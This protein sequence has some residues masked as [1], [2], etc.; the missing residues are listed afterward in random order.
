MAGS[1]T[2][3]RR[4]GRSSYSGSRTRSYRYGY[5]YGSEAPVLYPEEERGYGRRS[6]QEQERVA[7]TSRK[8]A[9]RHAAVVNAVRNAVYV[10]VVGM[11]CL[12]LFNYISLQSAVTQSVKQIASYES[13]LTSLKEAN[14][15]MY[16][17]IVSSVDLDQIKDRAMNELG[18]TYA[19]E[20]QILS[21]QGDTNDY[22]HMVQEVTK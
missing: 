19:E 4:S 3:Y 12:A 18:M 7:R 2:N 13:T 10:L 11:I 5:Q 14:D 15:E 9:V 8:S 16:N 6:T 21:Y 20:N 17:E 22:V 1:R